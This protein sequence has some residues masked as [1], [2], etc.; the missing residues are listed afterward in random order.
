MRL[1]TAIR[2]Y[3]YYTLI[4]QPTP[5]IWQY[6][7]ILTSIAYNLREESYPLLY[8]IFTYVSD[9]LYIVYKANHTNT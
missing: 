1:V 7:I 5:I 8:D 2:I 4:R 3:M 6:I 9:V